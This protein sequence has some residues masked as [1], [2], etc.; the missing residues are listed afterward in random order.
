VAIAKVANK[1]NIFLSVAVETPNIITYPQL[2]QVSSLV[3]PF[4][5]AQFL[6]V[7]PRPLL[8]V[9][10]E[11]PKAAGRGLLSR[12]EYSTGRTVLRAVEVSLQSLGVADPCRVD[13]AAQSAPV[14][15]AADVS[16]KVISKLSQSN[17]RVIYSNG[18]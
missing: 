7:P 1:S 6:P 8:P 9:D 11:G 2:F 16:R 13:W 18:C 3:A 17:K 14:L 10:Q 15:Q 12:R 4:L 5:H